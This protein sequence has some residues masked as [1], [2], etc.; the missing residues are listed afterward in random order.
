VAS[1]LA[2]AKERLR[3]MLKHSYGPEAGMRPPA[4][5]PALVAAPTNKL[6]NFTS[7]PCGEV[8]RSAGGGMEL[9]VSPA[10]ES[11]WANT[12][13]LTTSVV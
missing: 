9:A 5:Q 4:G 6:G 1:R 7:L 12:L 11:I 13:S 10:P 2:V 8:A 3:V